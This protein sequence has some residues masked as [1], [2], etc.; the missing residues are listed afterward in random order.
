MEKLEYVN[1]VAVEG[2]RVLLRV[3]IPQL[4]EPGRENGD[5]A[6]IRNSL[7]SAQAV[8][9]R[10]G[11]VVLA[12]STSH[13]QNKQESPS[14]FAGVVRKLSAAFGTDISFCPEPF[15]RET[16][17]ALKKL[18]PGQVVLL[19]NLALYPE[20]E[21]NDPSLAAFLARLADIYVYDAFTSAA[22]RMA[23]TVSLPALFRKKAAGLVIENELKGFEKCFALPQ[24]P[25]LG[26]VAGLRFSSRLDLI[27]SLSQKVD[28]LIIGGGVANT[29]LAAQGLQVGR[30]VFEKDM[31]PR[32][33]EA[34]GMLARRDTKVYLPVDFLVA[35]SVSSVGFARSVPSLEIP[36]DT[37]ALDIGP[38]SI[39]LFQ[40]VIRYSDTIF[41]CGS[42]GAS[43]NEEFAKGTQGLVEAVA[44]S[45]GVKV[46]CGESVEKNIAAM[47]L[48]HKFDLISTNS[49]SFC[50]LVEGR[51][52]PALAAL[53]Q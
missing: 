46:A 27:M 4:S 51:K 45:P 48:T 17:E 38:A 24:R 21:N 50:A 29:F 44:A 22:F 53:S 31:M 5:T 26:I 43:E 11:S 1:D 20:E 10:G 25:L 13:T 23:S 7:S 41:W 36:A 8:L 52:L 35:P 30:A 28:K 12:G 33:L 37:M 9:K 3:D 2:K 42:L 47:E 32:A 34:L 14:S 16:E 15:T 49:E 6:R 40:Q 19:E 39:A 18:P